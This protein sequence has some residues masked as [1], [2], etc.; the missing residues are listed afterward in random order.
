MKKIL[1][2]LMLIVPFM[3][4]GCGSDSNDN[5]STSTQQ[6]PSTNATLSI[7]SQ[8]AALQT[9]NITSVVAIS[10]NNI[11]Q[12]NDDTVTFSISNQDNYTFKQKLDNVNY[13]LYIYRK[14]KDTAIDNVNISVKNRL[15]DEIL[16]EQVPFYIVHRIYPF[17]Y[18]D[19]QM[20]PFLDEHEYNI[21]YGQKEI[22]LFKQIDAEYNLSIGEM[23]NVTNETISIRRTKL[24]YRQ[25]GFNNNFDNVTTY[26]NFVVNNTADN[27]TVD[28]VVYPNCLKARGI[29]TC[30]LEVTNNNN[31]DTTAEFYLRIHEKYVDNKLIFKSVAQ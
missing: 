10:I 27:F 16:N 29:N 13:R 22:I 30:A 5:N 4:F 20:I 15:G 2:S 18:Q 26:N 28:N 21:G 25:F 7:D 8:Y 12:S 19:N 14:P 1:Y 31:T 9:D 11:K 23:D 17:Y 6:E 3:L 24:H